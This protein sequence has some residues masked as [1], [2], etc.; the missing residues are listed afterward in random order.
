[1]LLKLT[2]H[3]DQKSRT[4][5]SH[6]GWN[7]TVNKIK[8]TYMSTLLTVLLLCYPAKEHMYLWENRKLLIG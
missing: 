3:I 1:M 2:T 8:R 7:T 6:C 5:L 4:P